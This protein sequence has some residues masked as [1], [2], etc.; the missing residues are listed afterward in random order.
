MVKETTLSAFLSEFN[1][2][3][4]KDHASNRIHA[5][6]SPNVLNGFSGHFTDSLIQS[7]KS[8]VHV[9]GVYEDT[10]VKMTG[11]QINPPS[12]GLPRVSSLTRL[13]NPLPSPLPDY[14]YNDIAGQGIDVFVLD[15]GIQI[16]QTDFGGRATIFYDYYPSIS[17]PDGLGHGTHV[18]GTVHT[19]SLSFSTHVLFVCFCFV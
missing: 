7:I 8:H 5:Q 14:Y 16:N 11:D 19:L 9:Q 3:A 6:Y 17:D 2:T 15:T 18:A 12:W 4:A 1:K 13:P 10:G